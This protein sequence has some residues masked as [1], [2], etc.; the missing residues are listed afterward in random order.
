MLGDAKRWRTVRLSD[1]AAINA[2]S[3]GVATAGDYEFRYIDISSVDRGTID[4]STVR[5]IRFRGSPSRARRV[6]RPDD[7]L[8]CTV[9]P[10]LQAH[11]FAGWD[12]WDGFVCSTG[13][14]VVR[15]NEHLNA[16]FLFH[17]VFSSSVA[18]HLRQ[19]EIGS[20]Y[21]AVNERDVRGLPIPFPP[22]AEQR[23]I[24]EVLDTADEAI[25]QTEALIAKLKQMKRGLLHDLLTRGLDENGELRDPLAHPDQF[26]DSP[27]GRIPKE[28][29]VLHV[30]DIA[31]TYAGG[32]PPRSAAGLY[33]GAIPW[34]KSGEVN[35]VEI[36][37][38]EETL[39]MRGLAASAARWVEADTP[40]MAMYG[41][42]AG[43]VSWLRVRA[44]TNQAVLAIV[45][46]DKRVRSRWMYWA[47]FYSKGRVLAT[48]QGSGQP[49]LSKGVI[50]R[51]RVACPPV[52]EQQGIAE[53]LDQHAVRIRTEES[54]RDKLHLLKNGLM[55]DL[56]TGRVR[57]PVTE[58]EPE[59][60]EVAESVAP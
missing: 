59:P 60:A 9:R 23:R 7:V 5:M 51:V 4:W 52:R 44:T 12:V 55:Q 1:V 54:Y 14:A 30:T 49:N 10:A 32:T 45:P 26:K 35:Q 28:W 33:G 38:T 20:S 29:D 16:R 22:L 47:L 17:L 2:E 27:L 57:L 37:V 13:F 56:L 53:T 58:G 25:R 31:E 43:V 48:V 42:T 39:S 15:P 36:T 11:A 24:A 50:D 21:P 34:V 3:L 41:A 8:L 46:R 6:V 19:A 40:L 18:G